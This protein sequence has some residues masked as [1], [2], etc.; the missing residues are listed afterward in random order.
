MSQ[1]I[2]LRHFYLPTIAL[3]YSNLQQQIKITAIILLIY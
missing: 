1:S 2:A 3:Y